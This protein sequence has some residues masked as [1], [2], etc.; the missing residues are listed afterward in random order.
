MQFIGSMGPPGGGRNPVTPRLLRHFSVLSF[1]DLADKSIERIFGTIL[2]AHAAQ[3]FVEPA[4]A[5]AGGAVAATVVVYNAARAALL[6][7][8]SR[9]HYSF[10]LRDV[11][12]VVQGVMRAEPKE[13]G[14]SRD[15]LLA[16]WLHESARVF[17]DRLIDDGD[18][19]WLQG[20]QDAALRG[21]FDVVAAD[22]VPPGERLIYGDFIVPGAL[23]GILVCG[24]PLDT[25]TCTIASL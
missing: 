2:S 10:N 7:T 1:T 14:A 4:A 9:A 8:P 13:A 23:L 5:A 18:A 24:V 16:L 11:A 19:A 25:V 21:Q 17:A 15:A 20:A 12:R 6:P 3:H 22:V